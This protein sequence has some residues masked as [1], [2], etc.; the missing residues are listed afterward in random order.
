MKHF[1]PFI[2]FIICAVIIDAQN[3][4]QIPNS[5]FEQWDGDET[6]EPT[7]WNTFS[8]SDG[9]YAS[10]AS[11]NHHYRRAGHRTG[12]EGNYYLTIYTKSIMGIKAN[13]NMTTGRVHAGAV[14][15][16]SSSN[17]NYTQRSNAD[18]CLPFTATPD[19]LY[20]WVSFYATNSTST[21]Q[22]AAII[23]GDSDFK[24]PNEENTTSLFKGRAV[25]QTT[26]T[27]PSATVPIWIQ[28]K[29]PFVYNGQ[30]EARYMLVNM[31]TNYTPGEGDKNDSLMI[32]DIE[33]IYSSWLTD[34]K[35]KGMTLEGF[36]K[37]KLNYTIHVDDINQL[38]ADNFSCTTEVDD[39][40]VSVEVKHLDCDTAAEVDITVTAED[41]SERHYTIKATTGNAV[42]IGTQAA[43]ATPLL[44][45][46][47]A[48]DV[49]NIEAHGT[50]RITDISGRTLITQPVDGK[51]AISLRHLPDGIYLLTIDGKQHGKLVV[52]H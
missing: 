27:T 45:P 4:F 8:S 48:S 7:H 47:P 40:S 46:N 50:V 14:S 2:S 33:L 31:T 52:K 29:V 15:A 43:N 17:Y 30:S 11:S 44:Y 34:I 24:A 37:G 3:T 28:L 5:G 49:V 26:P 10:L 42:G 18:H 39:A 23:H 51:E 38:S 1:L 12:G 22:I 20:V 41:G 13:G 35:Y 6:S 25:A 21:A 16:T 32:D 36:S 9:S 19:S